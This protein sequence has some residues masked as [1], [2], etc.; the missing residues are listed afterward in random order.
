M[1][2]IRR[3]LVAVKDPQAKS[4]PA[5]VKA[6]QLARALGADLEHFHGIDNSIYLD[7]VNVGQQNPKQ[8]EDE[9]R[10]QILQQLERIAGR[11]R[12]RK[13]RNGFRKQTPRAPRRASIAFCDPAISLPLAGTSWR[14]IRSMPSRLSH[15]SLTAT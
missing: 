1:R 12:R 4:L 13:R 5:V 6:T 2:S 10:K 8:I 14:A 7:T 15:V 11:V 9:E 3:I